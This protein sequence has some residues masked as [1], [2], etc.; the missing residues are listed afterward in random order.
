MATNVRSK[1][2]FGNGGFRGVSEVG[3]ESRTGAKFGPN[4]KPLVYGGGGVSSRVVLASGGIARGETVR[5]NGV[6]KPSV[7]RG[8]FGIRSG[9][10]ERS[11]DMA[12]KPVLTE[13]KMVGREETTMKPK[14]AEVKP[15]VQ[16]PMTE[17]EKRAADFFEQVMSRKPMPGTE[18]AKESEKEAVIDKISSGELAAEEARLKRLKE[19]E[20]N[21]PKAIPTGAK[22]AAE[23]IEPPKPAEEAVEEAKAEV[24]EEPVAEALSV[25]ASIGAEQA[26]NAGEV[27]SV[28]EL[29]LVPSSAEL[30]AP[31]KHRRKRGK[32]NRHQPTASTEMSEEKRAELQAAVEAAS[33]AAATVE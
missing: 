9:T 14:L 18:G 15:K 29:P 13:V 8:V 30:P 4:K 28:A 17:R 22:P 11:A 5:V 3:R 2:Y 20:A 16:P 25:G 19:E 21:E 10:A 6:A 12:K 33:D 1:I 7:K 24:A 32:K 27:S 26:S 31:G 23:P